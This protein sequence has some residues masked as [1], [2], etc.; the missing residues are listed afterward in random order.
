LAVLYH[1]GLLQLHA[2]N[3]NLL[4]GLLFGTIFLVLIIFKIVYKRVGNDE[5]S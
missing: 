1:A 2:R 4:L 5:R 3:L